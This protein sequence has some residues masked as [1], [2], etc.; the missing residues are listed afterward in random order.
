MMIMA[1]R[2]CAQFSIENNIEMPYALQDEGNFPPEILNNKKTLS[3]SEAFKA[4]KHF[5]RSATSTK[6]LPH[7]G[8]GLNAYLRVT[9]PLR[10]YFDLLAQQQLSNFVRGL[11]TLEKAKIKS[12]IGTINSVLPK[13]NKA[14]RSSNEHFKCVYLMQHDN[15]TG[16]GVVV[17]TRKDN[18]LI[19]ITTLGLMTQIKFKNLPECDE[20]IQLH[21]A[22]VD[23]ANRVINFKAS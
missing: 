12:T 4:T 20:Q 14:T 13:V 6:A 8:L 9:S 10:R 2:V 17:D 15:W 16:E 11:P 22:K 23:L 3:L 5:K 19:M 21:L 1:G 7:Y 18:A